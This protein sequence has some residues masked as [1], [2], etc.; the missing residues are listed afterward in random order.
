MKLHLMLE[1]FI[2]IGKINVNHMYICS[3]AL[4]LSHNVVVHNGGGTK[5]VT[6]ER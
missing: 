5:C 3:K 2:L 4:K 1:N 6:S